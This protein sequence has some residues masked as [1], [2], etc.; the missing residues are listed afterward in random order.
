LVALDS[1]GRLSRFQYR[2]EPTQNLAEAVSKEL[3]KPSDTGLVVV[4]SRLAYA[5]NGG[6]LHILDAV[7]LEPVATHKLAAPAVGR[8]LTA[9][10]L[11]LV[12][13]RDH[14]LAAYDASGPTKLQFVMPLGQT[15]PSGPPALFR[16]QL[17]IANRDGTLLTVDPAQGTIVGHAAVEQPLAG[18]VLSVEGHPVVTTIDGSLCRIDSVL[19]PPKKGP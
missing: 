14:E 6:V 7:T 3:E 1:Q 18:G 13:T 15:G 8:L 10:S 19:A 11:V 12:E 9:G 17:V 5:D 4:G 16:G 2:T